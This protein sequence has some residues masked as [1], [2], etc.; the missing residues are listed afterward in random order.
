MSHPVGS[1]QGT[2]NK[3]IMLEDNREACVA[4][5]ERQRGTDTEDEVIEVVGGADHRIFQE[6]HWLLC[7]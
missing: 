6:E 5:E 3:C 7:Q 1:G 2:E 4:R